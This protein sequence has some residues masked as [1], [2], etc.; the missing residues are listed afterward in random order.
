ME[1]GVLLTLSCIMIA[2]GLQAQ[3]LKGVIV[4]KEGEPVPNSTVYIHEVA[5][6]IAADHLGEFQTTLEPGTYTCE[7]RSLGYETFTRQVTMSEENKV[8]RVALQE[9]S[10]MLREVV[11]HPSS[12]EDPASRIMRKAIAHAPY[13]RYQVKEYTSEAYIKGSLTIA[14]IPGILKRTMKVNNSNF[15]PNTLIGKPLVMESKSDIRFTSPESY[16]QNVT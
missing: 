16:T 2:L 5:K 1:R 15:D 13:Y 4:D 6:G 10:Y 3:Q 14:K 7:F 12:D 9:R 8:I 11:V